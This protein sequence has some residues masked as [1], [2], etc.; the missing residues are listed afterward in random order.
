MGVVYTVNQLRS[1]YEREIKSKKWWHP[2]N[3]SP[4]ETCLV[5]S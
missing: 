5:N 4:M 2:L 1:Y 3:Y